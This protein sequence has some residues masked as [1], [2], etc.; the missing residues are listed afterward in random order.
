MS[1]SCFSASEE[2][3]ELGCGGGSGVD[4]EARMD[5]SHRGSGHCWEELAL[6]CLQPGPAL[7]EADAEWLP[8][9]SRPC[10]KI[11]CWRVTRKGWLEGKQV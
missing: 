1:L 2:M 5:T 6:I 7:P 4:H 10:S 11:S 8:A 3:E 9:F